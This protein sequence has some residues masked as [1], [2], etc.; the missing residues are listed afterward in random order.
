MTGGLGLDN[1]SVIIVVFE[2]FGAESDGAAEA[3]KSE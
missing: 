3:G 1:E 2:P